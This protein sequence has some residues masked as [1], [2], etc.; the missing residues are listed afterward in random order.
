MKILLTSY[1]YKPHVGGIENSLYYLAKEYQK[2]GHEVLIVASNKHTVKGQ[3]LPLQE[4]IDGIAVKRFNV[5]DSGN[6]FLNIFK[7][8][9]DL[10]SNT[11]FFKALTF[12]PDIVISR[13]HIT[14]MAASKAGLKNIVYVVPGVVKF[15]DSNFLN[16]K[17]KGV[18]NNLKKLIFKTI[19]LSF[20]EKIQVRSLN[21]VKKIFVFSNVMVNQVLQVA[22][23]VKSKLNLT[24]PGVDPGY[25]EKAPSLVDARK[26]IGID[27]DAYVYLILSRLVAH[28]S[29]DI[30]IKA[31]AQ[32]KD[33]KNKVLLIVGDGSEKVNLQNLA[34][35]LNVLSNTIFIGKTSTPQ[36][37]YAAANAFLLPSKHEPFGQTILEALMAGLPV[38]AFDSKEEGIETA[39]SEIIE[40]SMGILCKNSVEDFAHSMSKVTDIDYSSGINAEKLKDKFSWQTLAKKLIEA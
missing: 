9:L 14:A 34:G 36:L 29:I 3:G 22:P 16:N 13:N 15:Q 6:P 4:T 24:T 18:I 17:V 1:Y 23:D 28:K 25:H 12:G 38:I 33:K 21:A 39:S 20:L 27:H 8:Q 31:F 40:P 19:T 10:K 37:Y 5:I 30:A 35:S 26:Q 7:Y 11:K 32:L 2:M